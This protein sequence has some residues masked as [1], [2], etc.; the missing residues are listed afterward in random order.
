MCSGAKIVGMYRIF[1]LAG[2]FNPIGRGRVNMIFCI[3]PRVPGK[4]RRDPSSLIYHLNYSVFIKI[5]VYYGSVWNIW[6]SA[7]V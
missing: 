6:S 1:A 3:K 5:S 4:P 2:N 7:G